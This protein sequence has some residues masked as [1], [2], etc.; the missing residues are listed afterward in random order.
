MRAMVAPYTIPKISEEKLKQLEDE[1]RSKVKAEARRCGLSNRQ[2]AASLPGAEFMAGSGR[3]AK[4]Q[5]VGDKNKFFTEQ[6]ERCRVTADDA[7]ARKRQHE[8]N[9]QTRWRV[10]EESNRRLALAEKEAAAKADDRARAVAHE[11]KQERALQAVPAK[12][13]YLSTAALKAAK[14]C[15]DTAVESSE[16]AEDSSKAGKKLAA[17]AAAAVAPFDSYLGVVATHEL[18]EHVQ[19]MR[20]NSTAA[21]AW[22]PV[23]ESS[24]PT[25]ACQ[26]KDLQAVGNQ[27]HAAR[28]KLDAAREARR[29]DGEIFE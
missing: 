10:E 1:R 3:R 19:E 8:L 7:A 12:L 4:S 5:R 27:L 13:Y 21:R 28:L 23:C 9:A 22:A 11:Q 24:R 2:A 16:C 6:H 26:R 20:E 14:K 17:A 29:E 18:A 25:I 15:V